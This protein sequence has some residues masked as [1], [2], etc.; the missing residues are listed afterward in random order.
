MP[1]TTQPL[2]N[3][4]ELDTLRKSLLVN[5]SFPE[6][7]GSVA[8]GLALILFGMSR[9]SAGGLLL[10]LFGGGLAYRGATGHCNVYEHFGVNTNR[11]LG[12]AMKR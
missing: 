7:L 8:G 9:R 12:P 11:R 2:A 5:V 10:A 4:K 1:L 6:R 3:V